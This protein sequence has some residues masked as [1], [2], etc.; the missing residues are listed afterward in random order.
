MIINL[1]ILASMITFGYGT[2]AHDAFYVAQ[3]TY[4]AVVA[5]VGV[6]GDKLA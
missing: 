2:I 5:G 3:S 4:I 6:L 1:L